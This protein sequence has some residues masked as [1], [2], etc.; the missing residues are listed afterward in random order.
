[1]AKNKQ[2]IKGNIVGSE[3]Q[4]LH[5]ETSLK[6]FEDNKF[7]AVV[8]MCGHAGKGFFVPILFPIAAKNKEN[9]IDIV[10]ATPRVKNKSA[11]CILGLKEISYSEYDFINHIND[12]DSYLLSTT[13]HP[14]PRKILCPEYAEVITKDMLG[15]KLTKSERI[16]L[17]DI[18]NKKIRYV[19]D[20]PDH[21]I[22]QKAFAPKITANKIVYPSKVDMDNLLYDYFKNRIEY[23][24]LKCKRIFTLGCCLQIFGLD[25]EFG[26]R[27]DEV[28]NTIYFIDEKGDK[29]SF[30]ITEEIKDYILNHQEH[31]L[32][33]RIKQNQKPTIDEILSMVEPTA[34]LPSAVDK[35]NKR[36]EKSKQ[37]QSLRD[38]EVEPS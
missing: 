32:K 29:I 20:Y 23:L 1:M 10:K 27:L 12:C 7:Y 2:N 26:I 18:A 24:G 9:A 33:N 37:A 8:A 15:E 38:D 11:K 3:G 34:K 13:T 5:I 22:L 35:F 19:Q 16:M 31:R 21:C 36:L 17:D 28:N 4:I 6:N 14:E 25:N 30:P